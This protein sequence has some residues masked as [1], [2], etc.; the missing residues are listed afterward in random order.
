MARSF[1]IVMPMIGARR[2]QTRPHY[3]RCSRWL[4]QSASALPI[5]LFASPD[6][7]PH[8]A[9]NQF[10]PWRGAARATPQCNAPAEQRTAEP[11][12]REM[13]EFL[14]PGEE[15]QAKYLKQESTD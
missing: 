9:P 11:Y 8:A 5:S 10:F 12:A 1:L 2:A 6:A 14:K 3:V 4:P 13:L 15:S 7:V